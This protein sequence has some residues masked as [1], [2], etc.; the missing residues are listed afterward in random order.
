[1]FMPWL[2]RNWISLFEMGISLAFIELFQMRADGFVAFGDSKFPI[3]FI[4]SLLKTR[5]LRRSMLS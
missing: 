1:M 3:K 2:Q 5:I 4:Q